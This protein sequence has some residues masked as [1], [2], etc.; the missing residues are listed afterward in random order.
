M[1]TLVKKSFDARGLTPAE[2]AR[3]LGML[4]VHVWRHYTG[5]RGITAEYAI[6]YEKA[7]GI[8]RSELRP[9]LWP[10]ASSDRQDQEGL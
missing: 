2:A 1:C 9:D 4:Y 6:K 5:R 3:K 7:L 8:P 10:P